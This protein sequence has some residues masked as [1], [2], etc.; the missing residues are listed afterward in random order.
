MGYKKYYDGTE[1]GMDLIRFGKKV[2]YAQKMSSEELMQE[3]LK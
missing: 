2:D 3:H 1:P